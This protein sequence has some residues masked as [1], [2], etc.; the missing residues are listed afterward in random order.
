MAESPQFFDPRNLAKLEGLQL[1]ARQIVEGY[2]AGVHRSPYHGF[3]IEF[4]EHREYTPGDDLR[5]VDWKVFGRSDK[6]YVKQYEEET[7]LI[8]YLLVDVSESMQYRGPDSALSKAEYAQCLAATLAYLVVRQQDSVALA[9]FDDQLR[10]V[11][12][13]GAGATHWKHVLDVLGESG[14]KQK[15]AS[16]PIFHELAERWKKR[17]LVIVLS[18][19]FD[20][21]HSLLGGLRHFRHRRH[22]V[23]VLHVLDRA[24]LDF[25]FRR[26]TLFHGLEHLGD[27][28]THPASLRQ[29]YLAEF[30]KFRETVRR[31]CREQQVDYALMPTD[32]PIDEALAEYFGVRAARSK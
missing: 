8:C 15:T 11:V 2:V 29:G 24:E 19:L 4:A 12:R 13:P 27:V 10:D 18:D 25:P 26:A 28:L 3:S 31:G 21:L 5:Y 17:G 20:D 1:R 23:I 22:D 7:N 32:R 6:F 14:Q 30:N 9:T 16:G